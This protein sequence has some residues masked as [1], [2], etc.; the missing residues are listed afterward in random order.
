MTSISLASDHAG[1]E[2]K[3]AIKS[4]LETKGIHVEDFGTYSTDPVDYPDFVKGAAQ[5][6]ANGQCLL[7][8][9]LGGSGNE[10]IVANRLPG[11]RCAVVWNINTAQLSKEHGN[12]NMIAIG[13]RMMSEAKAIAVVDTWLSSEFKG[14]RHQRRIDKIDG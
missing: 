13:Q 11:I 3:E 9:I 8:I 10:A 2:Y 1:F 14:G 4:H 5:A 12:C 6:V 7:G